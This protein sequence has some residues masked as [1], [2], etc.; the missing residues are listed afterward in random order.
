MIR[1]ML[2]D[3]EPI[4]INDLKNSINQIKGDYEVIFE[5][6]D[7][8]EAMQNIPACRP[9]VVFTDIKMPGEN[10]IYLIKEIK[11]NIPILFPLF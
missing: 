2:V 8:Q 9:D 7:A 6:Y 1:I 3:D 11:K 4:F 10:G 5:A